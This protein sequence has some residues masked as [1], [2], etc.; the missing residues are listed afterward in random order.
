MK[1]TNISNP[2]H[3]TL[4][5]HPITSSTSLPS[6]SNQRKSQ[7]QPLTINRQLTKK[8]PTKSPK[9]PIKDI[10]NEY[11]RMVQQMWMD[12]TEELAQENGR[13]ADVSEIQY[14]CC[15]YYFF[16]VLFFVLKNAIGYALDWCQNDQDVFKIK[17][18]NLNEEEFQQQLIMQK[19]NHKY[20]TD[21]IG[22]TFTNQQQYSLLEQDSNLQYFLE[23]NYPLVDFDYIK[24][25]HVRARNDVQPK[26]LDPIAPQPRNCSKVKCFELYPCSKVHKIMDFGMTSH[27][28]YPYMCEWTPVQENVLVPDELTL[29]FLPSLQ[30]D[31]NPDD[32]LEELMEA[33]NKQEWKR[34]FLYVGDAVHRLMYRL[35][36]EP[37]KQNPLKML[38]Q[39]CPDC[40]I[41]FFS[42]SPRKNL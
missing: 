22:K 31:Q 10:P 7:Q 24:E 18:E 4:S 17:K 9:Q 20:D 12:I 16:L 40:K 21:K 30:G 29:R 25:F 28:S 14:F 3:I 34:K 42:F 38:V 27:P 5:N 39:N 36:T 19:N 41:H 2:S 15:Q 6:S 26:L 1:S 13:K 37:L 23:D 32:F 35:N 33:F 8:M 11:L